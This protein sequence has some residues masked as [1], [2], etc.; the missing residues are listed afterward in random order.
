MLETQR[1]L[2]LKNQELIKVTTMY[3]Q[4]HK[5]LQLYQQRHVTSSPTDHT[6]DVSSD[7]GAQQQAL[8]VAEHE[9]LK[10]RLTQV[11]KEKD[12]VLQQCE[13]AYKEIK[14]LQMVQT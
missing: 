6:S 14:T 12:R 3:A 9:D 10:A 1:S 13:A 8:S 4:T 2:E 11:L 7:D 5:E